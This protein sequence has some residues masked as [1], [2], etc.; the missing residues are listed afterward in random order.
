MK[1]LD[2]HTHDPRKM[3]QGTA[4]M[5]YLLM[6]ESP[7]HPFVDVP[8][9]NSEYLAV[10][11]YEMIYKDP[12]EESVLD[13]MMVGNSMK[14]SDSS[15]FSVGI[16]PW[17]LS[18]TNA[19]EQWRLLKRLVRREQVIAL[20]EAGLDKLAMAS[21]ELQMKFFKKQVELSER[22]RLPMVIHCVKAMEELLEIRRQMRPFQP[23]IWH[24]FRGKPAM[25]MQLIRQGFYLSFGELYNDESMMIV[26][27]DRLFL[28]TDNAEVGIGVLLGRAAKIRGVSPSWLRAEIQQNIQKVFF[29]A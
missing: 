7:L 19:D 9:D 2:I 13:V 12:K 11:R 8:G 1:L 20:G 17:E 24:G 5:N 4:I 16:H 15:Y 22:H 10:I 6:E 3:R 29:Q 23:W 14:M 25:A 18:E 28:E 27:A 26:P 21:M